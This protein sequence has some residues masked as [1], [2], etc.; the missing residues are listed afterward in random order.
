[1]AEIIA[2]II[3]VGSLLGIGVILFRKIPVL[4]E[5][6]E[7]LEKSFQEP[8]WLKFKKKIKNIPGLKSF[9]FE[10]FLQKLLSRIR[11]LTLKTDN[12]TS[13]WL[14]KLREKSQK[15]KF[16]ENDNYWKE[17]KKSTNQKNKDLPG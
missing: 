4:V 10:M 13:G 8:S 7:V 16:Q 11:V 14:Q 9:S 5:L 2:I 3:L 12:K 17:I 1:M 15:N 6:P